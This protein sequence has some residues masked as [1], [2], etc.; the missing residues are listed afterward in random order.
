PTKDVAGETLQAV[1]Q[2]QD[3]YRAEL[4]RGN[5]ILQQ[6]ELLVARL[7]TDERTRVE[8]VCDEIKH[9]LNIHTLGRMAAFRQF[10]GDAELTDP[11]KLSLAISGWLVGTD[12]ALRKLPV[13]TSLFDTRNLV[14]QYLAETGKAKRSQILVDLMAQEAATPELVAKLLRYM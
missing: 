13:A 6:I 9:E 8:A 12:D 1:K 7:N 10:W 4:D 2:A 5:E 11:E 14:R 3:D